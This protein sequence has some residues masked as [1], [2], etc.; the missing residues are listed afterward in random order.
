MKDREN[1]KQRDCGL[2]QACKRMGRATPGAVVDHIIPLWAG[3][4]DEDGNKQ[5]LCTPCHDAKTAQEAATRA[6]GGS[7]SWSK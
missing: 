2:C 5:L 3:G 4:S 1:I 6:S 7:P